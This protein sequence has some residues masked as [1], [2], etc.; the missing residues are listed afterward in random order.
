MFWVRSGKCTIFDC[1]DYCPDAEKIIMPK[2][3]YSVYSLAKGLNTIKTEWEDTV[4]YYKVF[5]WLS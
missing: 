5:M 1:T 3:N 2:D 4:D